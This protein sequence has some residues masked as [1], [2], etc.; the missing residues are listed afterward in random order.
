MKAE[1]LL[2]ARLSATQCMWEIYFDKMVKKINKLVLDVLGITKLYQWII[3]R[4]E[5]FSF[6]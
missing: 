3:N 6:K 4:W 1:T 2:Q 5:L